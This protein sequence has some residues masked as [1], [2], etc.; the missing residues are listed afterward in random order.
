MRQVAKHLKFASESVVESKEAPQKAHE[1]GV[2]CD[3]V[4]V[5]LVYIDRC[6]EEK[7]C[8]VCLSEA[9]RQALR[10][11]ERWARVVCAYRE[12]ARRKEYATCLLVSLLES[13]R[14][15][16]GVCSMP[17]RVPETC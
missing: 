7:W 3:D 9:I 15:A 11:A 8:A 10:L 5:A 13:L 14:H 17:A 4:H 12:F 2:H 6:Q 1:P 16:E